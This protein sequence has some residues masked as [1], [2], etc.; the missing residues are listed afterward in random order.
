MSTATKSRAEEAYDKFRKM[1]P[2]LSS[3]ASSVLGHR[4]N[5]LPGTGTYTDGKSIF[6]KPPLVLADRIKHDAMVCGDRN[7][8]GFL[9]CPSCAMR[10]QVR[11]HLHHE[12]AH[13]AH[14]SFDVYGD[15]DW[16]K[17]QRLADGYLPNESKTVRGDMATLPYCHKISPHLA[18]INQAVEDHR[19]NNASYRVRPGLEEAMHRASKDTLENGI[20]L[21]DGTFL[22]WGDRTD[23]EQMMIG[24]LFA[25]EGHTL[26]GNLNPEVAFVIDLPDTQKILKTVA[27]LPDALAGVATSMELLALA[28][29]YG[30]FEYKDPFGMTAEER[31]EFDEMLKA[32]AKILEEI[33]G[34]GDHSKQDGPG[35]TLGERVQN[36]EMKK[37]I[38]AKDHLDHVPQGI[39]GIKVFERGEG[40]RSMR[41]SFRSNKPHE[42]LVGAAVQK[43]RASMQMNSRAERHRNQKTGRVHASSLGKRAWND[44]DM[45]MFQ[46][47][48]KPDHRDYE[49]VIGFDISASTNSLG[50]GQMIRDTVIALGEMCRR[51]GIKFS[52]YGHGT[53]IGSMAIYKL[54][55]VKDHWND[56]TIHLIT[57]LAPGGSNTDGHNLQYYRKVL[58][59][60]KATDKIMMY[61]TDGVMPGCNRDEELPILREEIGLFR[62]QGYTLLGVGVY[63]SAPEEHGLPTAR[64]DSASDYPRVIDMLSRYLMS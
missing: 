28:R 61:V 19:I 38:E 1:C 37:V 29:E 34:H 4:V 11:V 7:H 47:K 10:E 64:V 35:E 42:A 44:A 58:D 32:L 41:G 60:S 30:Y 43:A 20:P 33:F 63:T 51:L 3:Y 16:A 54:K 13:L 36:E 25:M 31:D 48:S 27:N 21:D 26:Y 2:G 12:I 62:K 8:Q 56:E 45:R 39:D 40:P 59:R 46:K 22:K 15:K 14:G 5:V 18:L 9:I 17:M 24:L 6:I 53:E 50:R 55:E 57:S 49:M 52:V 23:D